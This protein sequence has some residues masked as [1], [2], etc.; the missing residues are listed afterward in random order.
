MRILDKTADRAHL[1]QSIKAAVGRAFL[2]GFDKHGTS[3]RLTIHTTGEPGRSVDG[4]AFEAR[5]AEAGL[6]LPCRV[7]R[8]RARTL[9][10]A[11]SLQSL[12]RQFDH[13]EIIYDPTDSIGNAGALVSFAATLRERSEKGIC[14]VYWNSQWRALYIVLDHKDFVSE[15]KVKT[16]EIGAI[17]DLALDILRET[18]GEDMAKFVPS[19][20]LGFELP[21]VPLVPVDEASYIAKTS[22]LGWLRG[23]AAVQGMAAML[24]L[25]LGVAGIVSA[26]ALDQPGGAGGPAVSGPN[27]KIAVIGGVHDEDDVKSDSLVGLTGSYTLP[28]GYNY[29]VQI[30]G[31]AGL[32]GDDFTGGV[33]GHLFWRDPTVGLLGVAAGYSFIDRDNGVK[34]SDAAIF[35]AEGELYLDRF[36]I[37]ALAGVAF[38]KNTNDDFFGSVELAWYLSDDFVMAGGLT[39]DGA[40]DVSGHVEFEFQPGMQGLPGLSLFARGEVG[41]NDFA[42]VLVGIRYYFGDPKSL[43]DRHRRDDPTENIAKKA[44]DAVGAEKKDDKPT[45]SMAYDPD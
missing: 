33:G 21:D 23:K 41:G 9:D 11:R 8:H 17:E 43:I 7:R 44:F 16:S 14:G 37:S 6:A 38:G 12:L 31:L 2:I 22:L 13:D 27:G 19:V 20:R 24:G 18:C 39:H 35:A 1:D 30:D 45:T 29:G 34:N 42:Q 28:L 26:A 36:T 3:G 4:P 40:H 32:V 15:R 25:G 5:L 10:K